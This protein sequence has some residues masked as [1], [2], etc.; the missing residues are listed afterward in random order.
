VTPAAGGGGFFSP[1]VWQVGVSHL[2][3]DDGTGTLFGSLRDAV[4]VWNLQPPGRT[5]VIVVMDSLSDNA[6]AGGG[7]GQIDIEIGERSQLLIVAG[8]WPLEPI[9][10]A[11]PGSVRRVPGHFDAQQVRAHVVG[12]LSVR[13]HAAAGSDDAGACFLNGLLIEGQL[14]VA[15]G[16]LGQLALA[17]CTVVPGRGALQV[18]SGGNE[19]LR[20]TID[21]SICAAITV[22]GAIR[23][24][25]IRDTLVGDDS[26]SPDF[27]VDAR[28]TALDFWRTSLFGA[29]AGQT[30]SASDCI[31]AGFVEA[32][33]RQTGCVR[34]SYVS[35][36]SK[37]PRRYRCQP[38]L[39]IATRIDA[40][41]RAM[42]PAVPTAAQEAAIRAEVDALIRPLFVSRRYGDPGFG[43]LELRCAEQ[44]R[45]GAESGAEMGAFEFLKQPQ[46]DANLRDALAE[47]LRFG[48]EARLVYVT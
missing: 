48:L 18:A 10:G 9:P 21:H 24:L 11:R 36:P 16:N 13:G 5:G 17:H 45:T 4:A 8:E 27:S 42:A 12:G 28:E 29:V 30:L 39:E 15:P 22:A 41:R 14:E 25:E 23:A 37:V 38:D 46:R 20:V 1:D 6:A 40:L 2:V 44:I 34:F 7:G 32:V 19:R 35:P 47:Y 33:R 26:G 3:P 43:Q 31:F